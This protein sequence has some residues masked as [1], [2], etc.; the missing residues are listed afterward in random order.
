VVTSGGTLILISDVR[1]GIAAHQTVRPGQTGAASTRL[2]CPISRSVTGIQA[3][4]DN[5]L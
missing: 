2:P 1:D 3:G 5:W 4:S